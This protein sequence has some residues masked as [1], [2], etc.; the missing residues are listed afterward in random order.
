MKKILSFLLIF[1]AVVMFGTS[2]EEPLQPTIDESTITWSDPSTQGVTITFKAICPEGTSVKVRFHRLTNGSEEKTV[3]A[4][5]RSNIERCYAYSLA[6]LGGST[7]AFYVVGYDSDG[8]ECYVSPEYTFEVPKNLSPSAV[9]VKNIKIYSPSSLV[10]SDGYLEGS[11]LTKD[12]EYSVDEEKTWTAVIEE[13]FIRG[14]SPGKVILRIAE[15]PTTEAGKTSYVVVPSY[16]S[17]TD[18]DGSDGTSE[19]VTSTGRNNGIYYKSN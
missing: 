12:V 15:T 1:G 5:Y 4:Q 14:L 10:A 6:L 19:G 3:N 11:V 18:L 17:N 2:C 13:R 7:Y 8:K 9:E 16:K